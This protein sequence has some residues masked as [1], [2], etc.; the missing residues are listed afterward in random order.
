MNTLDIL[1]TVDNTRTTKASSQLWDAAENL[2][3]GN[4]IIVIKEGELIVLGLTTRLNSE[5]EHKL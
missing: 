5:T 3:T 1:H 4:F 2:M